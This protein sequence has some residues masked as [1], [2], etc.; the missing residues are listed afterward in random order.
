MFVFRHM[1]VIRGRGQIKNLEI[2]AKMKVKAGRR[3]SIAEHSVGELYEI[4]VYINAC[5]KV[6]HYLKVI[7]QIIKQNNF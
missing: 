1:M 2:R 3:S 7:I 6:L 4:P 5:T